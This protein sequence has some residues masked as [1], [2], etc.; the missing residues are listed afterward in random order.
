M[1]TAWLYSIKKI[2]II[3]DNKVIITGTCNLK[4]NLWDVPFSQPSVSFPSTNMSSKTSPLI[5]NT[6]VSSPDQANQY[7]CNYILTLNKSKYE[8][9]QYLYGCLY[10]PAIPTL[11]AAIRKGNLISWPGIDRTTQQLQPLPTQRATLHKVHIPPPRSTV[12]PF[13]RIHHRTS[14]KLP[15]PPQQ[16]QIHRVQQPQQPQIHR[17]HQLPPFKNYFTNAFPIR[18]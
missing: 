13:N 8:L 9:A 17:A 2:W 1:I 15:Q 7:I 4:D 6:M 11:E 14:Q 16:P 10:A 5:V 18:Q 3:K 12:P